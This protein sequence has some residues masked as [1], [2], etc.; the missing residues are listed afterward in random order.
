MAE[1][2]GDSTKNAGGDQ[3][4]NGWQVLCAHGRAVALVAVWN[5]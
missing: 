2:A 3:R 4:V 1:F 5:H